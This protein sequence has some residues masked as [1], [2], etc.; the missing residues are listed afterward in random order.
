M[1]DHFYLAGAFSAP[2]KV[3]YGLKTGIFELMLRIGK[4]LCRSDPGNHA[5]INLDV[6]FKLG[7]KQL[8]FRLENG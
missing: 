6:F 7:K 8:N 4:R 1:G 5:E 2:E 3:F